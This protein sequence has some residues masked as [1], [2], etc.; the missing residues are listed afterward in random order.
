MVTLT[1]LNNSPIVINAEMIESLE[2]TPDTIITL[3]NGRKI[4]VKESTDQVVERVL[5]YKK[6]V[7]RNIL[8]YRGEVPQ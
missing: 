4:L 6:E 8:F 7:L 5:E 2:A 1:K 3:N